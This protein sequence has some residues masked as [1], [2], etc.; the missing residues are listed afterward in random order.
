MKNKNETVPPLCHISST[1]K[2]FQSFNSNQEQ[3]Y[4][5]RQKN[6][7]VWAEVPV[8]LSFYCTQLQRNI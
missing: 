7:L 1:R 8:Q 3:K 5:K 4:L 2:I 6:L